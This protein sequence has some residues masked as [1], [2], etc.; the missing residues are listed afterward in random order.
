V[1]VKGFSIGRRTLLLSLLPTILFGRQIAA[2]GSREDEIVIVD[3]WVLKRSD[4][5]YRHAAGERL[6]P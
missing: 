4:L 5:R 1:D 2:R 6:D 3:G